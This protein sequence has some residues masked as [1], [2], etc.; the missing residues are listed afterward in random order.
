MLSALVLAGSA[1]AAGASALELGASEVVTSRSL[2]DIKMSSLSF[3]TGD[4]RH[5]VRTAD[6]ATVDG[7]LYHIEYNVLLR[8]GDA[9]V[10]GGPRW[11]ELIDI[12]G[13]PIPYTGSAPNPFPGTTSISYS[14]GTLHSCV[15]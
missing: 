2:L 13:T 5:N 9:P 7:E 4:E 8:S 6:S 15:P 3:P 1:L 10:A 12:D 11:G 14:P